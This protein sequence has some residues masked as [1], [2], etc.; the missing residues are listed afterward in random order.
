MSDAS[1]KKVSKAKK[2]VKLAEHPKYSD[3]I[4][5]AI[6]A[7]KERTGSSR[8]A[9]VKY[10]KENYKV[11]DNAG[12]HVRRKSSAQAAG[13]QGRSEERTCHWWS[14]ETSSL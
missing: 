6:L 9:I 5:A 3:M 4:K 12:V 13:H 10:I 2:Q 8:Q 11:G 1:A 7:L 14:Q